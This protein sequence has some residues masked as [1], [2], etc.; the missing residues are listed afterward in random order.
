[1]Q[2]YFPNQK[3]TGID[4]GNVE[5]KECNNPSHMF[6]IGL[7]D[8]KAE[9]ILF[10]DWIDDIYFFVNTLDM[11]KIKTKRGNAENKEGKRGI[12]TTEVRKLAYFA[13][14]DQDA[15]M[16]EMEAIIHDKKY[17]GWLIQP[18]NSDVGTSPDVLSANQIAV[19]DSQTQVK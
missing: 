15:F 12:T 10:Y 17:L 13:T 19:G 7:K 3:P 4:L 2:L 11:P 14:I 16:T 9:F 6:T 5:I 1:M 8:L 18:T